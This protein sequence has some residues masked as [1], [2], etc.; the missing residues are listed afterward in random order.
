[1][2]WYQ[3]KQAVGMKQRT[4]KNGRLLHVNATQMVI[5]AERVTRSWSRCKETSNRVKE[6]LVQT[7]RLESSKRHKARL[8]GYRVGR[9]VKQG[10]YGVFA[11]PSFHRGCR[12]RG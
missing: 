1:M 7:L 5:H 2:Q 6:S 12:C 4:A 9:T 10:I 3:S 8:D 11:F